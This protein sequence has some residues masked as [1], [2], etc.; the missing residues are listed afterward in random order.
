LGPGRHRGVA[1]AH[2]RA[3]T[4]PQPTYPQP[5]RPLIHSRPVLTY[6]QPADLSTATG[7]S[8]PFGPSTTIGWNRGAPLRPCSMSPRVVG[9]SRRLSSEYSP[10][11]TSH[12]LAQ[13]SCSGLGR[14]D[15]RRQ[16]DHDAPDS[17]S[18]RAGRG[19]RAGEQERYRSLWEPLRVVG[20]LLDAHWVHPNRSARSH[21]RWLARS[22]RCRPL[23]W[24]KRR[25]WWGCRASGERFLVGMSQRRCWAIRWYRC[26]MNR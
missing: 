2:S 11:R 5:T 21:L 19:P 22:N 13:L 17:G 14:P 7:Q 18:G 15:R 23:G 3:Q 24:T 4:A 20:A 6:P 9:L 16:V 26:S 25:V 8:I 1:R 10:P 12:R